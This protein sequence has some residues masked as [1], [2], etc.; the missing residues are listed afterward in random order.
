MPSYF[1]TGKTMEGR[2]VTEELEADS[3][4]EAQRLMEQRGYSDVIL[5]TDD[6]GALYSGRRE[7][8]PA[9][10][11]RHWLM[12]RDLPRRL[13]VFLVLIQISYQRS[14]VF[15]LIWLALLCYRRAIGAPWRAIDTIGVVILLSPAAFAIITA[16]F[17]RPNTYDQMIEACSWGRWEEVLERLSRGDIPAAPEELAFR[18]ASALAGL[19]RLD[20]AIKSVE[21]FGD[22]QA[23]PAWL[24]WSRLA[25]V[26]STAQRHE[27]GIGCM[28]H[29]LEL[30]PENATL[31]LD[32]A[33]SVVV[34]RRDSRTARSLLARARSH[35][36][37]D[38][39]LSFSVQLDGL[40]A[41]EER[42]ATEARE[43]LETALAQLSRHRFASPLVPAMLDRLRAFIAIACAESGEIDDAE[44][45]FR[46][47]EPRLRALKRNDLIKRCT[48]AIGI[49]S[50]E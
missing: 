13:A 21:A 27:E 9:L 23:I 24:Y 17:A 18:K 46:Q 26:Y 50:E 11:P 39:L 44:R 29:A 14:W 45:Y 32:L 8:A 25:G 47:A 28:E 20:E 4:D 49:P 15:N 34:H 42:R 31:L 16:L 38:M 30:A 35:T 2:S 22:G 40:I 5:H 33:D 12:F 1:A 37:S 7:D 3:A 48:Q 10:Q 6:A 19:G 43:L 36:L 41:L